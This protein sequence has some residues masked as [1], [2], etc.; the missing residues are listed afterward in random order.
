[1]G[2]APWFW[3][4]IVFTTL[5]GSASAAEKRIGLVGGGLFDKLPALA[6]P[7]IV[8]EEVSE[9][10]ANKRRFGVLGGAIFELVFGDFGAMRL[11]PKFL[12]KGTDLTVTLKAS[13]TRLSGP[14]D[15]DYVSVPL[16]FKS[17]I[18]RRKPVNVVL[19]SGI[20]LDYLFRA[21]YQGQDIKDDFKATDLS[22]S[23]RAGFQGKVGEHG[24]IGA[25]FMIGASLLR[26]DKKQPGQ[27][28]LK[29]GGIGFAV[30]YTTSVGGR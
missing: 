18:F 3:T 16:M 22:V 4:V 1:M 27:G 10:P 20:G 19:L 8:H 6:G 2:R 28:K 5:A 29:N 30:E 7:T 9:Q 12:R 21:R 24:L 26:I 11:E 13:G 14:V 15:L 25:H 23:S 17:T